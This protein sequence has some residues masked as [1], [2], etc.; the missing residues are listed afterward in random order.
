MNTQ[1]KNFSLVYLAGNTKDG[2]FFVEIKYNDGRLSLTGVAGPE[3]NG[4]A[5]GSCGQCYE[6]LLE[7]GTK[8]ALKLHDVWVKYHLNDMRPCCEHQVAIHKWEPN[9]PITLYKF[10]QT[11]E[12]LTS[13][14]NLKRAKEKELLENRAASITK[15]EQE[16]LSRPYSYTSAFP[17]PKKGY[18]LD[19]MENKTAGW[20][21]PEEHPDGLLGKPCPTCDYRYGS[22]WKKEPVPDEVLEFLASLKDGSGV[23]P[24]RDYR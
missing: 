3:K 2:K 11:T 8:T 10:K 22:A 24:W 20:V 23:Y 7:I 1:T 18:E 14:Y 13:S 5:N 12:T 15:E 4:N 21:R 19:K 17:G 6:Y 9:L 16:L